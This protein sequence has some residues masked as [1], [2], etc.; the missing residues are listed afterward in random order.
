MI[1]KKRFFVFIFVADWNERLLKYFWRRAK[2]PKEKITRLM[3]ARRKELAY[4]ENQ[5]PFIK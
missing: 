1:Y 2:I 5:H 3:F 4:C